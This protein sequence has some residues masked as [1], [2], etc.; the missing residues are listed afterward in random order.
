M[1]NQPFLQGIKEKH[2]CFLWI[3]DLTSEVAN[4]YD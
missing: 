3:C 4:R 2:V 1:Y